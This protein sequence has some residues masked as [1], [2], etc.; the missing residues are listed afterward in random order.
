MTYAELDARVEVLAGVLVG[1]G[2]GSETVVGLCLPRSVDLVV[3][4]LAVWRAGGAFLP[5]DPRYPSSRLEWI[6]SDAVPGLV[7][8]D[9]GCRSVVPDVGVP[10]V[11][12]DEVVGGVSSGVV[13]PRVAGGGAA[14]VMYT[15]GSTGAPK[16]VVVTHD[17]VLNGVLRLA[18][19]VGISAG[20]R[21]L[22]ASSVNFDVCVFEVV[23][24]LVV[25]AT[26]EVVRDVLVVG[27]RGGWSG[28]VI[29][30]VPSVFAEVLDEVSGRLSVDVVV[31]AG[32][33][34]PAS[35]VGR[36][37]RVLP[38]VRVVNAYGQTESF[39]ASVFVVPDVVVSGSVPVGGPLGNMRAYVLGG[40]L[41]PVPVGAVG[42]LYV[43]GLIARGYH[44]RG[45]LTAE[46]FV[47]DP[48]GA[49]GSRMYRTGDLARWTS[50]GVLEYVGRADAQ[51]KVR[52]FR[53][54]PGEVEAALTAHPDIAQ[55][56]VAVDRANGTARL[57]GYVVP[58][59]L[60]SAGS[61]DEQGRFSADMTAGL[62]E[63]ALRRFVSGR[64]PE[65]MVPSV[66]VV[67]D[68]LPLTPNG[69]LDRLGLPVPEVSVGEYRAPRSRAEEVLAGVFAEVL[70]VARVGVDDDFFAVGGDSIRSIQVVSRARLLGVEVTPRQIFE[71]RTVA[72]L[73]ECAGVDAASVRLPELEGGGVGAAPLLPVVS[74]V[75]ELGAGFDRFAMSTV[76]DLPV[77]VD[78]A[79]LVAV[80][81]VVVD[82]HDVLRGRLVSGGGGWWEVGPAGGVD[83][84]GLVRRVGWVGGW[85]ERW[86][87]VVGVELE[88][89]SG[90][91]DPAGGVVAQ[92]VWFDAGDAVPGRLL[93]VLHHL[94]V[95]G[96][97]WRILLPDL[98]TAWQ[99][100][101]AGRVP[102]L[103]PVGTSARRWAHALADEA[104]EPD[105]IAELRHWIRTVEDP[106]PLL[107]SR[108]LDPAV[109]TVATLDVVTVHLPEA[110]TG[111]LL[112]TVPSA[113]HGGV[114]DGL[115]AGL[116][117]ALARWR[118]DRG[119]EEPSALVRLEGHGREE[120]VIPGA[121]LSR[122]VGWFTSMY[123]VRL[124]LTGVDLDDALAGGAAA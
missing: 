122:T 94:V 81:A 121:D 35:L 48:F 10:V 44:G 101:Q 82:H 108:E 3:G 106:D 63:R 91:L 78:L 8:T 66:F 43:G 17:V 40:G 104:S 97:S 64:L 85:D 42:E 93:M 28:S 110:A 83:V 56:A 55:A 115:L 7:L 53:I 25:G 119:V 70:G 20:S 31:F 5:V 37:R 68:R 71:R 124:D 98:A 84:A 36:V 99:Q 29:S 11:L 117:V 65:F 103:A 13:L 88:G 62:S 77:G 72:E 30:A 27:E 86:R 87:S 112:T 111:Q 73:A 54:E 38:G 12:V 80:V 114:D 45:G 34:L 76:V 60:D 57:V 100:Y 2:V 90:R 58:T 15:S 50:A 24:S 59:T 123:P 120:Q 95:D 102:Q 61:V 47:A 21:V 32:E 4:V 113:F 75:R 6:V 9:S 52:G 39:Y 51:V 49:V 19:R 107:G 118:R 96:V 105:R 67:L 79:A 109:D 1:C 16:G 26:V 69:K 92:F 41:V 33:A 14:Y 46:R 18:E 89:A 23:T 22:A 74:F 116:A